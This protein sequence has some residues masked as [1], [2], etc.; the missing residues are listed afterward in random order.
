TSTKVVDALLSEFKI[1][2]SVLGLKL[3][4]EENLDKM[5]E[6]LIQERIEAR[7]SKDFKRSDEIRDQ[8]KE[9]N[10][11]LEDTAQGTRWKLISRHN[12]S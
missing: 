3:E 8:L 1:L 9:M 10:I 6:K 11:V 7:K 5:V 4:K 2:F 12:E